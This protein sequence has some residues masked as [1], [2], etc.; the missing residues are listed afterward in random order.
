[1]V[2]ET[3]YYIFGLLQKQEVLLYSSTLQKIPPP[4]NFFVFY[5]G[6]ERPEDRWEDLLLDAYENLTETPNLELKVLTLNINEGHNE[7]LMEQCLIL[8]E[9]AQYVAKVRNYTKEMK[10]DV[11]VEHANLIRQS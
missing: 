7:E 9:Y 1:M 6:T 10:L 3:T 11:A 8:K 4:P 5:N 2:A